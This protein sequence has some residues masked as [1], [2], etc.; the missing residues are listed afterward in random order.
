MGL[1]WESNN[2]PQTRGIGALYI[3]MI[4]LN[5]NLKNSGYCEAS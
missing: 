4:V 1:V 3:H 5:D 2:F